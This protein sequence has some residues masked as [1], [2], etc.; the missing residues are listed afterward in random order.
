MC[1]WNDVLCTHLFHKFSLA[2]RV[3]NMFRCLTI[4]IVIISSN[5]L[6]KYMDISAETFGKRLEKWSG[7]GEKC[8]LSATKQTH[9]PQ[10][11]CFHFLVRMRLTNTAQL[12][13]LFL[14]L[15]GYMYGKQTKGENGR[16]TYMRN[17]KWWWKERKLHV[18]KEYEGKN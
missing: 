3:L 11:F 6:H 7:M 4:I 9:S 1:A 14:C 18:H 12:V 8:I 2:S 10:C 13:L 17:E 16:K 5:K 15:Y